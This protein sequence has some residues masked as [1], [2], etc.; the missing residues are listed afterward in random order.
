MVGPL[1]DLDELGGPDHLLDDPIY[2]PSGI[3]SFNLYFKTILGTN[4]VATTIIPPAST[5]SQVL[6]SPPVEE[7]RR[8]QVLSKLPPYASDGWRESAVV[9]HDGHCYR[10]YETERGLEYCVC[11]YDDLFRGDW[12]RTLR[13]PGMEEGAGVSPGD[14]YGWNSELSI[15][16]ASGRVVI[17]VGSDGGGRCYIGDLV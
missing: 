9:F 8:E 5:T 7:R 12:K 13:I 14:P 4:I 1:E 6:S 10:T 2:D 11:S 3:E 15:D 16:E 17:F